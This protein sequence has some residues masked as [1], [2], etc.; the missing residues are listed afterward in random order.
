MKREFPQEHE[1]LWLFETEPVLREP[2]EEWYCTT[3]TFAVTQDL[4]QLCCTLTPYRGE[5]TL[6]LEQ[7]TQPILK[8]ELSNIV[9]TKVVEKDKTNF[10]EIVFAGHMKVK[11]LILQMKPRISVQWGMLQN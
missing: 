7:G 2:D 3:L 1:L 11:P 9:S 8:L 6:A 4:R 5:M 10:L